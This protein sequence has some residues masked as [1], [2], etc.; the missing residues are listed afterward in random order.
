MVARMES[1]AT[2]TAPAPEVSDAVK[3]WLAPVRGALG[4]NFLAGYVTGSALRPGFDTKRS[5]VNV[6]VI[7]NSL[8]PEVLDRIA[9]A[10]REAK[11]P[12]HVDPLFMTRD[13]LVAS[14]DV[15]PIEW[16]DVIGN[17]ALIEGDD[18]LAGLVVPLAHLRLQCEHELRS[19]H[20]RLRHEYLASAK[21]PKRLAEVLARLASGFHTLFRTLLRLRGE[22]PPAGQED[23]IRRVAELYALDGAALLAAHQVRYSA[24]RPDT[25]LARERYRKF[26]VE[27]ERL[28]GAIDGL[29]IP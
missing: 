13:Q 16:L 18:V 29:R 6:L 21:A 19:K 4:S 8:E 15:F 23:V 3:R 2:R 17:H 20:L 5:H 12:P 28:V 10:Q 26:L 9:A 14:L 7:A 25:E 24:K 22:T 1:H 11:Q 27:I